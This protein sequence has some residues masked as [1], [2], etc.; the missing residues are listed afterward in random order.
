MVASVVDGHPHRQ[1]AAGEIDRRLAEGEGLVLAAHTLSEAY[2]V[3]T[4]AYGFS[5][6]VAWRALEENYIRKAEETVTLDTE[7]YQRVVLDAS[8]QGVIGGRIYDAVIAACA[9]MARVDA[10]V[11]FN[12]RHFLDLVTPP[13]RVVVP[14]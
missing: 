1:L 10:L 4:G 14:G 9:R 2:A 3:L 12:D 5:G 8:G 6:A 11:T 7:G 13:T